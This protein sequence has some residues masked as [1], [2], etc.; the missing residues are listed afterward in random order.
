MFSTEP[1]DLPVNPCSADDHPKTDE[2]IWDDLLQS[3]EGQATLKSLVDEAEDDFESG[4]F[5]ED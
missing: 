5:E 3:P 1:K 2:Q 4:D